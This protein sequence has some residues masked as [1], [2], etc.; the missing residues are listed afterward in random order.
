MAL[1]RMDIPGLALYGGTTHRKINDG[2]DDF[3][4][5]YPMERYA[6]EKGF[7]DAFSTTALGVFAVAAWKSAA[8][9]RVIV[10]R[11]VITP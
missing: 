9:V 5:H 8:R 10:R 3:C 2:M 6:A 4:G 1:A 11:I 7:N